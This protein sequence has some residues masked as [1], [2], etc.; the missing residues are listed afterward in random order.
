MAAELS[1]RVREIAEERD[2]PE[3]EVFEQALE[4]G[5]TD[6]WEEIILGKYLD[7]QLSREEAIDIVGIEKV[8]RVEREMQAV[9]DDVEWGL[10]I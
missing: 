3:S 9:E 7:E 2:V 10:N 5:L 1:D 6:L 8:Q 4:R